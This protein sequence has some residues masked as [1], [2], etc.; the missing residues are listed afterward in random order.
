[1]AN[2]I[3]K[4]TVGISGAMR[5]RFGEEMRSTAATLKRNVLF[6]VTEAVRFPYDVGLAT[7]T[8]MGN[9]VRVNQKL[10]DFKSDSDDC[11]NI[12]QDFTVSAGGLQACKILQEGLK[13]STR[14]YGKNDVT[15]MLE[16]VHIKQEKM[17]EE[18]NDI[19]QQYKDFNV[20]V[21]E[22]EPPEVPSEFIKG[23][24]PQQSDQKRVFIR[25]RL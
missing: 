2:P 13:D 24:A 19:K 6:I 23:S 15:L 5:F 1:M 10:E 21:K 11:D 20:C 25:S 17:H 18:L 16:D 14:L 22:S 4:K 12:R 3:R 9:A 8:K 7:V